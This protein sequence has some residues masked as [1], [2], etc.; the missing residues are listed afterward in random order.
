MSNQ[1]IDLTNARQVRGTLPLGNVQDGS[2]LLKADG[3]VSMTDN[4]NLA[5]QRL[6]NV[7]N[8]VADS[9]AP[10][11][12]QVKQA[13]RGVLYRRV[14]RAAATGNV[15][16][17]NPGTNTFDGVTL[18]SGDI[19][20][21]AYQTNQA[22]NGLY[23]F[24]GSG[25]ALT[26]AEDA[27]GNDEVKPGLQVFVSE[28]STLGN[29]RWNL[30]TDG[31]IT[32]DTTPLV[33]AQETSGGSYSAGDGLILTGS[34]FSV[35]VV[36]GSGLTVSGSGVGVDPAILLQKADFVAGEAPAGTINGSN[37]VFTLANTPVAGTEQV[38]LNGVR[39]RRGAGLD[40]TISGNTITF[41]S[42][43]QPGDS[44]LVD[45]LK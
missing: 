36:S 43:P 18:S 39:Q 45:Y 35:Q 40:Y 3:S 17:S 15:N 16:I 20:F 7:G 25:A 19:L 2:L 44:I 32:V 27:D 11:W 1:K 8:A 33:F 6:L 24:N 21:L 14:A 42:A 4:F 37:T 41:V 34:T 28:G 22:Q 30:I 9:D 12:G 38:Y 13:I 23:V 10:N 26:R 29:S 5:G 31:P